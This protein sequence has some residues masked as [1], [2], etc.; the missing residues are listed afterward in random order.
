MIPLIEK[1]QAVLAD[2]CKTHRVRRLGVFGSALRD[3]FDPARSDLDLVVEFFPLSP[4]EHAAAYLNL[5]VDLEKL[6][7]MPVDVVE[8]GPIKNPSFLE[9]LDRRRVDLYEAA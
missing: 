6:F 8:R 4:G 7:G 5:I 9:A 1:N 3:T 2:L